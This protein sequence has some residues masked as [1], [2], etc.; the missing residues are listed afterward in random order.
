MDQKK[1]SQS[2][3]E[4]GAIVFGIP[5]TAAQCSC[6]TVQTRLDQ[7]N[8][9]LSLLFD[10]QQNNT[11]SILDGHSTKIDQLEYRVSQMLHHRTDS[12]I[13]GYSTALNQLEER[14]SQMLDQI[15]QS[16]SSGSNTSA[17]DVPVQYV[18]T[19][20]GSNWVVVLQRTDESL[21]FARPWVEYRNGFGTAGENFWLGLEKM[22][23]LTKNSPHELVIEMTD[24]GGNERFARYDRFEIGSEEQDYP[25][26][27]LGK[28]AG[29]AGDALVSH[30]NK[31]FST[32][33]GG[34]DSNTS[35]YYGSGGWWFFGNYRA[36]LTGQLKETSWSGNWW[37]QFNSAENYTRLKKARMLIRAVSSCG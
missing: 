27:S 29:S 11:N 24:F 13:A 7:L 18:D 33:D 30:L 3:S 10:Q 32:Y 8:K 19:Q 14:I 6:S 12:I 2:G 4:K 17:N 1:V 26:L 36:Y 37:G 5:V 22:H 25:I 16:P 34:K 23:Q 31:G 35:K 9:R 20:F 21:N 28:H 15:H